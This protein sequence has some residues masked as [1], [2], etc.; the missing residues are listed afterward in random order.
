MKR[1][2]SPK[3]TALLALAVAALLPLTGCADASE[4]KPEEQTFAFSGTTLDVKA[5]GNPTDLIPADR[6]D[7]KVTRWFDTGA[8]VGGKK[9]SWTLDD[10]V[11][12]LH[13]GCTGLADCEARFRVEVPRNVAVTRDGRA[14]DL[15][16]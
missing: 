7:V 9:L 11:L 10:G 3:K 4:A 8:Q 15:K 13:A 1:S 12:D 5:H 14:T 2:P 16:G 6:T